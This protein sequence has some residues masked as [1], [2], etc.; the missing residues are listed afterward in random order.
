MFVGSIPIRKQGG[1][2]SPKLYCAYIDDLL[3]LLRKNGTGCWV[4]SM[5]V[6]LIGYN[7]NSI[8]LSPSL[9]GLQDMVDI[10]VMFTKEH[11]LTFST[12]QNSNKCKTKCMVFSKKERS[13]KNIELN[14][15]Y[16]P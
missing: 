8:L 2:L 6:G 1:V 4:N 5:C 7:D 10:C 16:L 9:D 11:D 14:G 15:K 13:L 12:H 3:D